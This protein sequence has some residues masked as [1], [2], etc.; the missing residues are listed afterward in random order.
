MAD[1][2]NTP[3]GQTPAPTPPPRST[4]PAAAPASKGFVMRLLFGGWKRWMLF[5]PLALFLGLSLVFIAQPVAVLAWHFMPVLVLVFACAYGLFIRRLSL[6]ARIATSAGVI[7]ASAAIIL[8]SGL[9]VVPL[10]AVSYLCGILMSRWPKLGTALAVPVF[11]W[12]VVANTVPVVVEYQ[13]AMHLVRN[14]EEISR[15]PV[16]VNDRN[17]PRST[18]FEYSVRANDDRTR[19]VSR[20]HIAWIPQGTPSTFGS[21][22]GTPKPLSADRCVWQA[23]LAFNDSVT[24]NKFW[25]SF[26]GS[27]HGVIRIDCTDVKMRIDAKSGEDAYFMFGADSWVTKLL[28]SVRHPLSEPAETVYWQK[29]DGTWVMLISSVTYQPTWSGTMIP[30]MGGVTEFDSYGV[31]TNHS[32]TKAR[33]LFGGAALVSP[34]LVRRYGEAYSKFR[35][36]LDDYFWFQEGL[37]EISE[38]EAAKDHYPHQ[39]SQPHFQNFEGIG[40]QLVLPFEPE[41]TNAKALARVLLFDAV[42]GKI[43]GFTSKGGGVNGPR[44][45]LQNLHEAAPSWDWDQYQ[46]VEPLVVH[47]SDDRWYYKVTIIN[48]NHATVGIIV[49]D[50]VQLTPVAF[51]HVEDALKYIREGKRPASAVPQGIVA[52]T[53]PDGQTQ[54]R[55]AGLAPDPLPGKDPAPAPDPAGGIKK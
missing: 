14:T 13:L 46:K 55:D 52:P 28:F 35:Y 6:K 37:L 21:K 53:T 45:S 39:N 1:N 54:P 19:Q 22:D 50:G 30:V 10:L 29:P 40:P 26:W 7:L 34:D 51:E 12:L 25:N 15:F 27:V 5:A 41:G 43:R 18:A 24:A 36:G 31:M 38:D 8:G 33:E 2:E 4:G 9:V 11:A 20:V 48:K 44:T 42:S 49:V 3:G 17:L 32:L 47:T 16:T 23:P